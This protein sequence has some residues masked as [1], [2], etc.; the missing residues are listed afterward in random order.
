MI[1]TDASL[2]Y[3]LNYSHFFHYMLI[4]YF[5]KT[6][7]LQEVFIKLRNNRKEPINVAL[8]LVILNSKLGSGVVASKNILM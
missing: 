2:M 3:G 8:K 5:K 4:V 7:E 1:N 6:L